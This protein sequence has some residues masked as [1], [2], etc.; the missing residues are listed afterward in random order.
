LLALLEDTLAPVMQALEA[1]SITG[2]MEKQAAEEGSPV[3]LEAVL[4]FLEELETLLEE[5][6]PE[7]EDKVADLKEQ[8]GGGDHRKF[9][10]T[11]SK[12]VGEFEFE[13]ARATL[14]SLRKKLETD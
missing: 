1:L 2:A 9:V 13:D 7:A 8:L 14:A 10:N 3:D 4:P 12:Q 6:D 11:L 5:M